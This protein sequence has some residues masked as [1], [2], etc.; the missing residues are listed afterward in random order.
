MQELLKAFLGVDLFELLN[1]VALDPCTLAALLY[2]VAKSLSGEKY[3]RLKES[4]RIYS[5]IRRLEGWTKCAVSFFS[6]F[7]G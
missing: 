2:L 4:L 5:D 7:P 3:K 1:T 6:A